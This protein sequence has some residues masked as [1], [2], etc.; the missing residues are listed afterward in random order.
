[1]KYIAKLKKTTNMQNLQKV[2]CLYLKAG[3]HVRSNHK[4]K[5]VY[6]CDKHKHKMTNAGTVN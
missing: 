4:H 6:T 1:M 5:V 3:V 2:K